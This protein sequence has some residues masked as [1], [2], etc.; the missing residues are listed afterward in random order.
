MGLVWLAWH[1]TAGGRHCWI[2][3]DGVAL[4]L[5][6]I[7]MLMVFS[8]SILQA[9]TRSDP[10]ALV[11]DVTGQQFWWDVVYDPDGAAL[12]DANEIVL[13]LGRP[14]TL[15]FHARDV[16]QSF[17]IPSLAGKMD[18][19]PG[20]VTILT[21]TATEPGRFRSQRAEFCGLSHPKMAFEAV[22]LPPEAF[23]LWL[24]DLA[25]E[26]R[27][28]VTPLQVAGCDAFLGA[29]CAACHQIRGVATGGVLGPD[30][31]R[32]AAR[33][34]LGAGMWRMNT[35]NFAG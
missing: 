33:V 9:I 35:G 16:I 6:S 27:D 32:L 34:T 28:A 30:L 26:A 4:P 18:M 17:W 29:G 1:R 12:R 13:P 21:L 14:V 7:L 31:T 22:V 5:V 3:A 23:N 24:T 20:R 2:W 19:I 8:T 25:S 15:R 11:I 10:D